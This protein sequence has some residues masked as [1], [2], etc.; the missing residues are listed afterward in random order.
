M[1]WKFFALIEV[2]P[3]WLLAWL[4]LNVN[5][6]M[7]SVERIEGF[8]ICLSKRPLPTTLCQPRLP[9]LASK[10]YHRFNIPPSVT[11][12]AFPF[13]FATCLWRLIVTDGI[14]S[15]CYVLYNLLTN[16][17]F[18][19]WMAHRHIISHHCYA[20]FRTF[21]RWLMYFNVSPPNHIVD[22]ST[23][24]YYYMYSRTGLRRHLQRIHS[25]S[26]GQ[27]QL[28]RN[29]IGCWFSMK[30]SSPVTMTK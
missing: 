28:L 13:H 10:L 21:S 15:S 18:D 16:I 1:I 25:W 20:I 5:N 30:I 23:K 3:A 27:R 17:P 8:V 29:S 9:W 24:L 14:V 6:I 2:F 22:P 26:F 19:W 12:M 11:V 4:R 7:I